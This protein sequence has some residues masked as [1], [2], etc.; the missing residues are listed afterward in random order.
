[1]L[2]ILTERKTAM[3][4][5]TPE[6]LKD[7][8]E[9]MAATIE[10]DAFDCDYFEISIANVIADCESNID[11]LDKLMKLI[12]NSGYADIYSNEYESLKSSLRM[13]VRLLF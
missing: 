9:G 11:L 2:G 13:T 10:I 7:V 4:A 8:I 5:M 12:V 1:M 3:M 6:A